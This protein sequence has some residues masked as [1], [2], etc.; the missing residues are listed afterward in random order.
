MLDF[1]LIEDTTPK[2]QHTASGQDYLG[3][4][5]YGAFEALQVAKIIE[6]HLDYF[7]DFRWTTEQVVGKWKLLA[8]SMQKD[9]PLTQILKK[10]AD[11]NS[12]IIAYAD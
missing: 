11:R 4:L 12:G 7:K 9:H 6:E 5:E 1:Y 2:S 10:A 3:G 8:K